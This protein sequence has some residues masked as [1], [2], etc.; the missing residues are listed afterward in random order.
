MAGG[1]WVA[2]L[3]LA[4]LGVLRGG[5][6][7]AGASCRLEALLGCAP[8]PLLAGYFDGAEA[9]VLDIRL[10]APGGGS[11]SVVDP[12]GF[13]QLASQANY[14]AV[15]PC[16]RDFRECELPGLSYTGGPFFAA[17]SANGTVSGWVRAARVR[18]GWALFAT[19]AAV[20]LAAALALAGCAALYR[21]GRRRSASRP[22]RP[23]G[24]LLEGIEMPS[25]VWVRAQNERPGEG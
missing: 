3:A 16:G 7:A 1:S 25:A 24:A 15:W 2:W 8:A 12:A 4:A 17:I 18:A 19:Y 11:L 23:Q 5:C 9:W 13:A 21:L 10:E 20:V 6:A 14:T 22:A